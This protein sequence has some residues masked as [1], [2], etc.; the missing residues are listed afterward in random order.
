MKKKYFPQTM[1][2]AVEADRCRIE[3]ILGRQLA[4][5]EELNYP[6]ISNRVQE[7]FDRH[8]GQPLLVM[9]YERDKFQYFMDEVHAA[10]AKE[11]L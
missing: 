2:D 6:Y 10:L 4:P 9:D 3:L 11:G 1:E 8:K 5:F 7:F